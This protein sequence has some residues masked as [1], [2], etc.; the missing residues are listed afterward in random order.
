MSFPLRSKCLNLFWFD[1]HP[2]AKIDKQPFVSRLLLRSK[3]VIFPSEI[4]V[5]RFFRPK[6][7]I[8]LFFNEIPEIAIYFTSFFKIS[9]K[10]S[11][12]HLESIWQLLRHRVVKDEQLRTRKAIWWLESVKSFN[13][14]FMACRVVLCWRLWEINSIE[15]LFN[16]QLSHSITRILGAYDRDLNIMSALDK[17]FFLN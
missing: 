4:A 9:E 8:L 11:Y 2:E 17:L 3:D 6:F 16:W 10:K 13:S 5:L 14:K 7:S 15:F 12:S 1:L